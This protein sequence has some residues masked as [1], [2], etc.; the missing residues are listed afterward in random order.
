MEK[1][2]LSRNQLYE[3]VWNKPLINLA[4]DYGLSDNGLRK[5]CKKMNIPLPYVGYWQ[6]VRYRKKVIK[7]KLPTNYNGDEEVTIEF[8]N[9]LVKKMQNDKSIINN[10]KKEIETNHRVNLEVPLRLINPDSLII[11]AKEDL[12]SNKHNRWLDHGLISSHSG[13][14][15]IKVTP[16][17]VPRALRFMDTLIKLLRARG[18]DLKVANRDSYVVIDGEAII[19]CLQEKL[20]FED[21]FEGKYNWKTRKYH[22]SGVLT[23]RIWK[24]YRFHQKIWAD[25]KLLIEDQLSKI[26]AGL[27]LLAQKEKAER[28]EREE[29][30]KKEK[31]KKR[32]EDEKRIK[33]EQDKLNFQKLLEQS[34]KWQQSLNLLVYI[35]EIENKAIQSN[36]M[37]EELKDWLSWAKEKA[38]K[39]NPLNGFFDDSRYQS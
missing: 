13:S 15:S 31:E 9:E 18:Y 7:V 27:E 36:R 20:G 35:A 11:K 4:K 8:S 6:K 38:E 23:F 19:I 34:N 5:I 12:T 17:N 10:L 32:I 30:W 24:T 29:Y 3:L 33:V 37:T 39:L 21:V 2:T 25:G 16:D 14:I 1:T 26:V 28:L 22:P